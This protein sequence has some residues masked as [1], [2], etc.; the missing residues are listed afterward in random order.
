MTSIIN[1]TSLRTGLALAALSVTPV[2]FAETPAVSAAAATPDAAKTSASIFN[3]PS[4]TAEFRYQP[5]GVSSSDDAI[6]AN[7]PSASLNAERDSLSFDGAQ[8]PPG[9]RRSYGR[10]RYQDRMHNSDGST[11]IAFMAGAGLTMPVGNTGK[12]YTPSYTFGVGAGFN[13]NRT[14]GVLGEFHYDHMGVTGGAADT[15]YNN[16]IGYGFTNS[17]LAGF[18]ANAHVISF[19]VNPIVNFTP[20]SHGGKMGAYVTG[21]A[22]WYR[23]TTNF[24]LPSVGTSCSFY[25]VQYYTNYNIDS[26]SADSFGVNVGAGLTYKLS[27]FSSERLFV[28]ARYT[29]LPISSNNNN[30]FFPFNR[31]NSEYIPITVGIRF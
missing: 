20:A 17:D 11:K 23:K 15:E 14:F 7:D 2:M 29:W 26:A 9:R 8:P 24:T 16:L 21:G 6:A 30:D 5:E 4:P 13:F 31:R 12:F 3:I 1:L 22:G 25:C 18:D 27:E 19:S 10:S 28:D